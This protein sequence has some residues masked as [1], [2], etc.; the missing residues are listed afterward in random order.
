[1]DQTSQPNEATHSS[2]GNADELR[3]I[4]ADIETYLGKWVVRSRRV[5][6]HGLRSTTSDVAMSTQVQKFEELKRKWETQRQREMDQIAEKSDE[7]TAAWLKLESEQRQFVQTKEA[8]EQRNQQTAAPT[9]APVPFPVPAP[10]HE[11][12]ERPATTTP[13]MHTEP[14]ASMAETPPYV[15]QVAPRLPTDPAFGHSP[16]RC[17]GSRDS[18][19]RQFQQLR[20]EV[21]TKQRP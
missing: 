1:M 15:P 12:V 9:H 8:W 19:V 17:V 3:Q 18:A 4:A 10:S 6:E 20:R 7:L 13:N 2:S 11:A 5:I 16:G 21:G 14:V